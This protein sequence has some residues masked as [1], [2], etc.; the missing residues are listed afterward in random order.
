M[1]ASSPS[2]TAAAA[3]GG[4]KGG[5]PPL[6]WLAVA[7]LPSAPL[8]EA[9]AGVP[10]LPE[11]V[12]AAVAAGRPEYHVTLWHV[13]DPVQGQNLELRDALAASIGEQAIIEVVSVDWTHAAVPAAEGEEGAAG[14][15]VTE[16]GEGGKR[17]RSPSPPPLPLPPPS[18]EDTVMAEAGQA[19]AA[20][21]GGGGSIGN[22]TQGG[23]V[24]KASRLAF[25]V[26]AAQVQLVSVQVEACMDKAYPHIT[27]AVGKQASAKD[28]NVLPAL[29]AQG[30]GT[31]VVLRE[32]LQLQGQILGF[33]EG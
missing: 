2:R 30:K 16:V 17:A 6:R 15:A 31:R 25:G 5:A 33:T 13:E 7:G 28:S 4:P 1:T 32:P 24:K 11:E 19:K 26:V 18:G 8:L 9:L 12:A 23:G 14:G 21:D 10:G 27:L 22:N 29:I 3:G 20:A